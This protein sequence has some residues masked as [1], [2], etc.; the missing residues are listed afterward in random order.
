MSWRRS[1]LV[2][3]LLFASLT[4]LW[5]VRRD[6]PHAPGS[7][8]V[9]FILI[10]AQM[11]ASG[12][13]NPHW[14][15]HPGSPF[16]YAYAAALHLA[17]ALENDGPW[18]AAYP[19]LPRYLERNRGTAILLG[20]LVS[21]AY[22]VLALWLVCL[23]G[24]RAFGRPVGLIGAWFALLSP[25]T[26]DHVDMARTDGAGL[27]FGFLALWALLRLLGQPSRAAHAV[28][29]LTLGL[30]VATRYFLAGLLPL[31]LVV[32]WVLLRRAGLEGTPGD[33]QST[34]LGLACVPL[35]LVAGAPFLLTEI[36]TVIDSLAHEARAT[37]PGADGLGPLGN[38]A[39]Y[40]RVALPRSV[41]P[42]LLGLAAIGA[43]VA[44]VR[45]ELGP[46]LLLAFV[47]VFLGGISLASLHWGRWLIQIL[48]ILSLLAA[49]A[50]VFL[51]RRLAALGRAG[52]RAA[53]LVLAS[54]VMAL[55]IGPARS[56]VRFVQVQAAPS[57]RE[58]SRDWIVR[59]LSPT[60]RIAADLYTAP[61]QDTPFER[62]DYVFSWA[63]V[64]SSPVEL[65]D[66][67]YDIAM[68]SS[69]VYRRFLSQPG[70][71]PR[72]VAFYQALFA[73]QELLAEFRPGAGGRGPVI[74]LYR[75]TGNTRERAPGENP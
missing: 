19:A 23:V 60:E 75:L 16:I 35:G 40:F 10:A 3:L 55:S 1:L 32:D 52:P 63:Q 27:F 49:A 70:R 43:I 8:E 22:G 41:P 13:L 68:V 28:A 9:D 26:L 58:R 25:I 39:W 18:L 12:D 48:P 14:F 21:V 2:A 30:G 67:G 53:T 15:G 38:L 29:G 66:R 20:R 65:H 33:L 44:V 17:N 42:V 74:R 54:C 36:P 4:Y 64:V 11:S 73:T 46:L 71:Y 31:L 50:L 56:Y 62:T 59:R 5:G 45:R 47:V 6:L 34:A 51:V 7:D 61:L 37:H 69:A 72:E 24:D 57:T